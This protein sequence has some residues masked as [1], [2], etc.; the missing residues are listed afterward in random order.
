[1]RLVFLFSRIGTASNRGQYLKNFPSKAKAWVCE[2][3][4]LGQ[5]SDS[6]GEEGCVPQP[7]LSCPV[8]QFVKSFNSR[9]NRRVR[10]GMGILQA[11][12]GK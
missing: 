2:P 3:C 10:Q 7:E 9:Q 5:Y 11:A 12:A 8:G 4:P 6:Q 1:M